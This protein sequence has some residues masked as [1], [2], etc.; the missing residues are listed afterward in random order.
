MFLV[1]GRRCADVLQRMLARIMD[2]GN[3]HAI[4]DRHIKE[5]QVETLV[6]HGF[7]CSADGGA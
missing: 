6:L 1:F 5:D 4:D 7:I 3:H 2:F